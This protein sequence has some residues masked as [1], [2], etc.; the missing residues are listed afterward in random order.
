VGVECDRFDR[1]FDRADRDDQNDQFWSFHNRF[2]RPTIMIVIV[3][4]LIVCSWS[5]DIPD[6]KGKSTRQGKVI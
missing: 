1:G 2:D 3:I 5:F 4:V 6:R